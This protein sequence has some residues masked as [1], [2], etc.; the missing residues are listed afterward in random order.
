MK[1]INNKGMTLTELLVSIVMLS[2]SMVLMYSLITN[3][4]NRKNEVDLRTNDLVKI[5]DIES[6]MQNFIMKP[7]N[8]GK[9]VINN[10]TVSINDKVATLNID[11]DAHSISIAENNIV[12]TSPSNDVTKW[13]LKDKKCNKIESIAQNDSKCFYI[14]ITCEATA[15]NN[16]KDY[17]KIPMC[18]WS[19]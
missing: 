8:Y 19:L 16:I 2:V 12:Y 14:L 10:V 13:S 15:N 3:L 4:Q 1:K 9:K 17:I 7:Y 5:A 11:S 18:F 6:N